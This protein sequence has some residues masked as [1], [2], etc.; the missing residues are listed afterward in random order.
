MRD[1]AVN[2]KIYYTFISIIACISLDWLLMLDFHVK[3]GIAWV[4]VWLVIF[5]AV[6]T[7][8]DILRNRFITVTVGIYAASAVVYR[9]VVSHNVFSA[10]L[11]A[12]MFILYM[13]VYGT[14]KKRTVRIV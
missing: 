14:I 8:R 4:C 1:E 12:S 13:A 11:T 2:E 6:N 9:A 3:S 10:V 5:A 7:A